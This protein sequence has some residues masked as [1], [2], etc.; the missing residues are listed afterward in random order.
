MQYNAHRFGVNIS[1]DVNVRY[2]DEFCDKLG[3][4]DPFCTDINTGKAT[5]SSPVSGITIGNTITLCRPAFWTGGGVVVLP[6][7][8]GMPSQF[9]LFNFGPLERAVQTFGH[10]AAHTRG[11]DV[12]PGN[13]G[14]FHPRA[15]AAG[16]F[17]LRRFRANYC[18]GS[19]CR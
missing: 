2:L 9:K 13:A 17:G 18:G 8:D 15:E 19:P 12:N 6:G 4:A 5:L 11:I 3:G 7:P 10:E 16:L 1:G 14:G